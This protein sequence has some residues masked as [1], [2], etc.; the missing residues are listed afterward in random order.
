[1]RTIDFSPL[2]RSTVGFDRLFDLVDNAARPDW[3]PYNIEKWG[4]NEYLISMAVAGFAL[5]LLWAIPTISAVAYTCAITCAALGA[6]AI[7]ESRAG[8]CALRALG[9]KTPW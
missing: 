9:I 2:F 8:W 4:D 6:F 5:L 7:F 1:M 3:P